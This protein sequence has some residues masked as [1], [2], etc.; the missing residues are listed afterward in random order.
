MAAAH[1]LVTDFALVVGVAA[2]TGTLARRLRQPPILGYLVAGLIVGPYIPIP[3][4][5]DVERVHSLS[6]LG[7]VLVMF[8]V[9]LE[10]QLSRAAK[11]LPLAGLAAAIQIGGMFWVGSTV[12]G[13]LGLSTAGEVVLGASLAVS[14]TMVVTK[15]FDVH[16]PPD[17]VRGMVLG[18][19]VLQDVVAI[20]L[21]TV[22]TAV[23]Q[24]A[25]A[26][27]PA[28]G[29]IVGGL[30]ATMLGFGLVGLVVVPRLTRSVASLHSP[31]VDAVFATGICFALAAV[32][33]ALGYSPAL[34]AFLAGTLVSESGLGVRY[35]H[36]VAPVR[37]VFAAVFF[38]SIG[39]TIDP[40][41]AAA[42][43][44]EAGLIA[45]V[46]VVL[47]PLFVLVAGL[48]S[49]LGLRRSGHAGLALGQIGEFAFIITGI[50]AVAGVVPAHLLSVLVTVA[51]LTTLTTTL[52]L[53]AADR[54]L[55]ALEHRIP[56]R[57]QNV[58]SMYAAW[59]E[60]VRAGKGVS[61]VRRRIRRAIAFLTIDA[62]VMA[63][64]VV[65]G[66]VGH[67]YAQTWLDAQLHTGPL[68]ARIAV[69]VVTLAVAFPFGRGMWRSARALGA[70]LAEAAFG[71]PPDDVADLA[72]TSRTTVRLAFQLV[73]FAAGGLVVVAITR[74]FLPSGLAISV[75]V[76]AIL[77]SAIALWRSGRPL[78]AHVRSATSI[79][80]DLLR[81]APTAPVDSPQLETL[82]HGLGDV[83]RVRLTEGA[84]AIGRSLAE[85]DLRART[86]ASV[87]ALAQPGGQVSAPTAQEPLGVGDVL[88]IAGPESAV[89]Q[90]RALLL[91]EGLPPE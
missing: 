78:Q 14:S 52:G 87:L 46:V 33:H 49:G 23:S 88:A 29:G 64:V 20:V 41:V 65:A 8:A 77:P 11:V 89:E 4:F 47:P 18:V 32:M 76:V 10:F 91:G 22:V 27:A 51:V 53:G 58:L 5:A 71:R 7:V 1:S 90:A 69:V 63:A 85:L 83:A 70:S 79:L 81:S 30:A 34:G 38:V 68:P 24:G 57:L 36:L 59:I 75:F 80:F 39:M 12:G 66:A 55:S 40:R 31:E 13:L 6:E 37:D 15:V 45:A 61:P 28:L 26:Q 25:G 74:P 35:E 84:P 42:H 3:L 82:L 67:T 48:L 19:L 21:I 44:G 54:L 50:G 16:P 73:S 56:D 60:S 62:A 2:V 9:G 43:L 86:G 17:D 72:S